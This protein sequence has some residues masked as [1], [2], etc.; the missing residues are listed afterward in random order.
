[1]LL[2]TNMSAIVT[3]GD[4]QYGRLGHGNTECELRPKYVF[5]FADVRIRSVHCG[6]YHTF[7]VT[8][9]GDLYGWGLADDGRLGLKSLFK[10]TTHTSRR[11]VL[12]PR[13]ILSKAVRG[14]AVGLHH[15][16]V[17]VADGDRNVIRTCGSNAT[18]QLGLGKIASACVVSFEEV[19]K[20]GCE[21]E[22]D[23]IISCPTSVACGAYHT[24]FLTEAA[25][26]SQEGP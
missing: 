18:G 1:M 19:G 14:A 5:A 11:L 9:R 10:P 8:R 12:S 4:G 15:S 2:M 22:S 13:L 16:A 3:Q 20:K 21:D 24:A 23:V 7:C 25:P 26:P 17:L 6:H